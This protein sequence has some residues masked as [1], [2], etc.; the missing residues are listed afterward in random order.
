MG[1]KDLPLSRKAKE[2]L[3]SH[4]WHA[5]LEDLDVRCCRC[6]AAP[7]MVAATRRCEAL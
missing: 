3:M 5:D 4:R 1:L 2:N 6:D 7:W